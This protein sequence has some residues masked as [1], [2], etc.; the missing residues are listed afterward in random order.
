VA[1]A[2]CGA[3]GFQHLHKFQEYIWLKKNWKFN[4]NYN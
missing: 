4:V 1:G 3:H 2:K